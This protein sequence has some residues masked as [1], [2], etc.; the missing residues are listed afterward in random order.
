M[1]V[2]WAPG[3]GLGHVTRGLA[4]LHTLHPGVRATLVT[5]SREVCRVPFTA[6]HDVVVVRPGDRG[7]LV[8]AG[9]ALLSAGPV[10]SVYLDA[11]PAGLR[12]EWATLGTAGVRTVHVARRLQLGAYH[13]AVGEHAPRFDACWAVEPLAPAHEAWLRQ[14]SGSFDALSL[15]DPPSPEEAAP[16]PHTWLVVHS[17]PRDEC[18]ALLHLAE[19]D[20]HA[21]PGPVHVVVEAPALTGRPLRYP[22]IRPG[23]ARIYSGAGFNACRQAPRT[24]ARHITLP[25]A[26]RFDDQPWRHRRQQMRGVHDLAA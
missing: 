3:A 8:E 13:A 11:F 15:M 4:V 6:A 20:A 10:E 2:Y 21:A 12:G 18:A 5:T 9:A 23:Y 22:A 14:R 25:F 16:P 17:G 26:R 19:R 1:I 24:G 7:S